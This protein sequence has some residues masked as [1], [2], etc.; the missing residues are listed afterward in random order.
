MRL[1]QAPDIR[2]NQFERRAVL[3]QVQNKPVDGEA[4]PPK[5]CAMPELKT[6]LD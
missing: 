4:R 6:E 3:T 2:V 5:A 1:L